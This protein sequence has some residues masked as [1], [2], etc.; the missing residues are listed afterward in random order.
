MSVS[1]LHTHNTLNVFVSFI[2]FVPCTVGNQLTTLSPT[3]RTV[4]FADILYYN[5][6]LNSPTCFDRLW[7]HRCDSIMDRNM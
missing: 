7:H 1:I 6:S 4:L 5:I 2:L 3:K